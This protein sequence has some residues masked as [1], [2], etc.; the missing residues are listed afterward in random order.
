MS[1]TAITPNELESYLRDRYAS[2]NRPRTLVELE[3]TKVDDDASPDWIARAIPAL[4]LQDARCFGYAL[5]EARER[6]DLLP[7][8]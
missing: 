4:T 2:Y 7:V 8:D 5:S 3:I 6:Y 1:R